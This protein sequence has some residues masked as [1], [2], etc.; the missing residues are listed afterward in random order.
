MDPAR[1]EDLY[2][3]VISAGIIKS[4]VGIL[5]EKNDSPTSA[6]AGAAASILTRVVSKNVHTL[7]YELLP[8][9]PHIATM[10]FSAT[11]STLG[12]LRV[13]RAGDVVIY[14]MSWMC[15]NTA[16]HCQ[17]MSAKLAQAIVHV[18]EP[19]KPDIYDS[20]PIYRMSPSDNPT[21]LTDVHFRRIDIKFYDI[22]MQVVVT[23]THLTQPTN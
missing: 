6:Q 3:L 1:R 22:F 9:I 5:V 19:R 20:D 8:F 23:Y 10:I 11:P 14:A 18:K 16:L 15:Y 7:V 4:L 2:Q 12:G 21:H 13:K 17:E